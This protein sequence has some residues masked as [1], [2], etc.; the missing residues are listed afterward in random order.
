ML[1]LIVLAGAGGSL[2]FAL[3]TPSP[4]V[5]PTTV[6]VTVVPQAG[7]TYIVV[8][9]AAPTPVPWQNVTRYVRVTG[10]QGL[11]L[12][13]RSAPGTAAETV[14]LV[15]DGTRLLVTGDGREA[16]GSLWWPVRD[17]GDNKEGWAVSTFLVPDTGP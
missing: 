13:I 17:L 12:R 10:T 5:W 11:S 7:P 16:D 2:A 6:L 4:V 9:S 15:P 1:I 14:E 8:T 3:R